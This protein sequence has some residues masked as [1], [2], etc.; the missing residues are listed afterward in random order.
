MTTDQTMIITQHQREQNRSSSQPAMRLIDGG[1]YGA[2]S[3]RYTL[4]SGPCLYNVV[5][6]HVSKHRAVR[7]IEADRLGKA[8]PRGAGYTVAPFAAL[9]TD[10]HDQ[11]M[12]PWP[13]VAETTGMGLK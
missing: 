11:M 6:I 7:A 8:P 13:D 3:R 12:M 10:S 4:V 2:K 9:T 1:V 5:I